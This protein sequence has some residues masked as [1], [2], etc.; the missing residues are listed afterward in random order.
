MRNRIPEYQNEQNTKCGGYEAA[1]EN[2]YE[3]DANSEKRNRKNHKHR[4]SNHNVEDRAMKA[5]DTNSGKN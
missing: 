5:R 4:V 3:G 2:I 1:R